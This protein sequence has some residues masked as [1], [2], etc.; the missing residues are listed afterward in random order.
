MVPSWE[1]RGFSAMVDI[2]H[3]KRRKIYPCKIV[4]FFAIPGDFLPFFEATPLE[5]ADTIP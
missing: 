1:D 2:Y 4:G 5:S 3:R